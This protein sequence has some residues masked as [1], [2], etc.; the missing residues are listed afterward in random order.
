[1]APSK[2]ASAHLPVDFNARPM[3]IEGK[4]ITGE[5]KKLLVILRM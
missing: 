4:D 3:L 5:K 1:M 2:L